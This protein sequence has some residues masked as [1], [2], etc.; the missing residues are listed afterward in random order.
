MPVDLRSE[1]NDHSRHVQINKTAK[2][3]EAE[4]SDTVVEAKHRHVYSLANHQY[5]HVN[6]SIICI[7]MHKQN[8]PNESIQNTTS[9]G[10]KHT[11]KPSELF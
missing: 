7:T 4:E 1:L 11:R 9:C 5:A 10:Y 2:N 3:E 6:K 8:A